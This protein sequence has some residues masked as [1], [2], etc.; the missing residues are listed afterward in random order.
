MKSSEVK[1][2][3]DAVLETGVNTK[4]Q[5]RRAV[6]LIFEMLKAIKGAKEWLAVLTDRLEKLSDLS[7][8]YAIDHKNGL[9]SPLSTDKDGIESGAVEID[10]VVYRLTLS[11]DR[12]ERISGGNMTQDF[13]AKLPKG[14]A[15]SK[16]AL[17][18]S[19]LEGMS[20]DELARYDLKRDI[21]RVWSIPAA[22]AA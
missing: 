16:L 9:D 5:Y 19:A 4:E 14:F 15:A 1:K 13:L 6:P 18:V 21:K 11:L 2:A 7:A 17:K 10:G 12:P 8:A 22:Q 20:P 3:V